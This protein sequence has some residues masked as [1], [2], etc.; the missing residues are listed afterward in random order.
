MASLY[1]PQDILKDVWWIGL[2]GFGVS[3]VMT[4]V[5]RFVAYRTKIVDR[6]DDLLKP[7]TK[8]IA[9]LGGIAIFFGLV[10]GLGAFLTTIPDKS[11]Y[12]WQLGEALSQFQLGKLI[13]NPFWNVSPFQAM[14]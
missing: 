1:L 14:Q 7:H 2:I 3:L 9:Y 13:R 5:V 11:A 10:V 4:P 8:P 12:W 6:P